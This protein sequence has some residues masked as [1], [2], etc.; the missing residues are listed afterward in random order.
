MRIA[1]VQMDCTP[2]E[3]DNLTSAFAFL[4]SAKKKKADVAVLPELF[5]TGYY[6]SGMAKK[7]AEQKGPKFLEDAAKELNVCVL[8]GMP[9]KRGHRI[10][11]AA[12][13]F[14]PGQ[15]GRVVY[16]KKNLF[17]GPPITEK[18]I[19]LAGRCFPPFTTPF[20]RIGAQ[21]C[22]DLRYPDG[23]RNLAKKSADLLV[24]LSAFS[25]L[26]I[27]H[28]LPLLRARAIENQV[29]VAGC[30][31]VGTDDMHLGGQSAIFGPE[32]EP[33]GRLG[34]DEEELLIADLDFGKVKQARAGL[35]LW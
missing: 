27:H 23:P 3:K 13:W 16:R 22:M 20:G 29:F 18:G 1:L 12:Y 24:Y 32:G 35:K 30:N 7:A 9:E 19:F 31:R 33:V 26:R 10:Y 11:N 15:K 8:A 14:Q 4:K 5:N 34:G 21:I 2:K 28:W 17:L 6:L 25:K